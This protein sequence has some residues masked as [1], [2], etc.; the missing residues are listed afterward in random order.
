[1]KLFMQDT[2]RRGHPLDVARSNYAALSRGIAMGDLA[3][4]D[5]RHRFKAAMGMLADAVLLGGRIE[6][7][8]TGI[9]EQQ[10]RA[11][12]AAHIVV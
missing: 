1:M 2:A 11:H 6:Q 3:I 8:W 4:V 9:I 12:L 7:E 5:N 10:K